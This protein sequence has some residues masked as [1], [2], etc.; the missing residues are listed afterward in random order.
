MPLLTLL[1]S[2][3]D[4]RIV[5]AYGLP[6]RS[7]SQVLATICGVCGVF[8]LVRVC[9]FIVYLI[10]RSILVIRLLYLSPTVTADKPHAGHHSLHPHRKY[11]A[12][13]HFPLRLLKR[14][15]FL[16]CRIQDDSQMC[17]RQL[18]YG[19]AD[20]H[21]GSEWSRQ[22]LID[23]YFGRLQVSASCSAELYFIS[24]VYF[25]SW[26]W[27]FFGVEMMITSAGQSGVYVRSVSD[28]DTTPN[29]GRG[30]NIK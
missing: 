19:S 15:F 29:K 21:H 9:C 4:G 30:W 6:W 22:V 16:G 14:C 17:L 10:S 24:R 26:R 2:T 18:R 8:V 27:K 1:M 12:V 25:K 20:G 28:V 11:A 7:P 3:F 5:W 23:E 13:E